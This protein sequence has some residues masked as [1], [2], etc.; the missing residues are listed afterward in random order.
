L[1]RIR[2]RL[3]GF[4]ALGLA[5]LATAAS[6]QPAAP[7]VRTDSGAL[8]GV[9]TQGVVRY[10]GIP[11][12]AP[13]VGALRWRPPQPAASW[14]GVRPADRFGP[15]CMQKLDPSDN[16]VGPGPASE[17][18]LTLNLFAPAGAKGLPVMVWIHGGGLVNGSASAKLYDGSALA[19]QGV[20]VV[21]LNYRL[22]RFGFFAHPSLSAEAKNEAAGAPL[23]NYGLMD[24]LAALKWV[25]RNI[26]AFGGDPS[27]VTVFGE[28]AGG[29]SVNRL[30]MAKAA[31]G[32]FQR[33]ISES[34]LGAEHGQ[35]L[36]EAE[37]DG[38]A[39]ATRLG[40]GAGG[41]GALRAL[42]A[43]AIVDAGPIDMAKGEAPILDGQLLTE[44][45]MAA[46]QAGHEA[47]VPYLVG[48]NDLEIPKAWAPGF[49]GR[50]KLS[51]AQAEILQAAY[52]S[53]AAY[54]TRI[55]TD[56]VF[57]APARALAKAHAS[58]GAATYLYRFAVASPFALK[59]FG[60]AIHASDRQYVFQTLDASPWPTDA[61]DAEQARR[62]SAYWAAFAR[63]GDPNGGAGG[64]PAWPAYGPSDQL[65][66]FTNAGPV[67]ETT[68]DA[69]VL[70]LISAGQ[71]ASR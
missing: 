43:Q 67:V 26:A 18:C 40:A 64:P 13:P 38:A 12:A 28:S 21:T 50:V 22:G 54:D 5:A 7:V 16:G 19:R 4:I 44:D 8:Q 15:V 48:S 70:D 29:A 1:D 10:L 36:A 62:I 34:G 17:D 71:A 9:E 45:P 2:R 25:K 42:P 53:Q 33:A 69:K 60:G 68:A 37:A 39:F 23:A 14:S 65:L 31:H 57:G 61:N 20:V 27:A 66:R 46:F 55:L 3:P 41:T 32:L 51:T 30:M 58:H 59:T 6:A 47:Q 11:Y 49:K 24:Q 63:T 52:G 56:V 35:T